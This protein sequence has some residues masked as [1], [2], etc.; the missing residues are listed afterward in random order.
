MKFKKRNLESGSLWYKYKTK[1]WREKSLQTQIV[2]NTM[3]VLRSIQNVGTLVYMRVLRSIQ[4]VG[5]LVYV[6][7]PITSG[8]I[9]YELKSKHQNIET[10][11][12]MNHVVLENYATG[13]DLV[14]KIIIEKNCP[15]LYPADLVPKSHDE[16]PPFKQFG[17]WR[18][19]HFQALWLSIIAEKC[20]EHWMSEGWQYSSGGVEELVHSYQLK[21]GEPRA[22]DMVFYNTKGHYERE[23]LRMKN[24]EVYDH[25]G[26]P[27][28]LKRAHEEV[29]KAIKWIFSC[30]FS[31]K[32][33]R[34]ATLCECLDLI[35]WTADMIDSGFYQKLY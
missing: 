35:E 29:E 19:D 10:K 26:E 17:S 1:V 18:Q 22:R 30:G 32:E 34:V 16:I 23:L 28:S 9:W 33:K 11:D 2:H 7:V 5:T 20:T 21:L 8:R 25:E 13:Y 27:I 4:N 24:I 3:R 15:V 31:A 12:L 6:S 14:Q